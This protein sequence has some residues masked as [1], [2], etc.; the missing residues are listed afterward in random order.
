[1]D[2]RRR[3]FKTTQRTGCIHFMQLYL[4]SLLTKNEKVLEIFKTF[5][6]YTGIPETSFST[7]KCLKNYLGT[8]NQKRLTGLAL[9]SVHRNISVGVDSVVERFFK[10]F[11]RGYTSF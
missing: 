9:L 6:D 2:K 1:M 4:F 7:L 10:V 3:K 8:T 5:S 11:R